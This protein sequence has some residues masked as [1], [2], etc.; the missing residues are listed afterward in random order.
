M[1]VKELIKLLQEENPEHAV[2]VEVDA[3]SENKGRTDFMKADESCTLLRID[4]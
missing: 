4:R 1:R 2:T 3:D